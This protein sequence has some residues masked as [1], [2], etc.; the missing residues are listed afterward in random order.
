MVRSSQ[1]LDSGPQSCPTDVCPEMGP[2]D[3]PILIVG[4]WGYAKF[5][6]NATQVLEYSSIKAGEMER[7]R[8]PGLDW[9][10]ARMAGKG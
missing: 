10:V 7:N 6:R 1:A 5:S 8:N 4:F 3:R 9:M 2:E